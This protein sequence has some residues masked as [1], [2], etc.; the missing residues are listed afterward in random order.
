MKTKISAYQLFATLLLSSYGTA[1][2]YFLTPDAKQDAWL[3]ILFFIPVGILLQIV[4]TE[5]YYQYP[6]D[7][8]VTYLPKI[9][10][11]VI[12]Y[13]LSILYILFFTYD[14]A[15]NLRDFSELI[16][17]ATMP[18]MPL[19]LVSS[20]FIITFTYGAFMGLENLG[21]AGQIALPFV[22]FSLITALI[23]MYSTPDL[24]KFHQLKP[25]LENGIFPVFKA[26]SMLPA[27]PYGE[28]IIFAMIYRSVNEPLKIRKTAILAILVLG[29]LLFINTIMFITTLG[30]DFAKTTLFPLYESMRLIKLGGVFG[31]LDVLIIIWMSI[32]GSLK[33]SLFMYAAML[34]TTQLFKKDDPKYLAIP[35]GVII[36][37]M[38]ILIA[39]N[40]AEH[41]WRGQHW[42]VY[43]VHYPLVIIVPTLAL[44]VHYI[45]KYWKNAQINRPNPN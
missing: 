35:L 16:L 34:G 1:A 23:F 7:T 29:T 40:Y 36:L 32:V 20:V 42:T 14:A 9:F 22:I 2:L 5:L 28:T 25:F 19:F 4:Y 38:S 15:R 13:I 45:K 33:V 30:T 26:G 37:T 11:K 6:E 17:M 24:V 10:G 31:R 18:E 41:I 3:T 43:Y 44:L 8:L 27:F 12:G 39:P 21:R